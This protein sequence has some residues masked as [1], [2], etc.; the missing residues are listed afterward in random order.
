M[1]FKLVLR[2]IPSLLLVFALAPA[3]SQ[4]N[5]AATQGGAGGIPIMV[6]IGGADF[7]IDWGAG[8]R[9]EGVTAWVDYF[10]WGM[11]PKIH[12]IGIE[13]E[14]R[15]LNFNRPSGIPKMRQ[16]TGMAGVIYSMPYLNSFRP[17]GK[18]MFGIGSIDF[19]PNPAVP[20]YTHDT[21]QTIAP[22]GGIDY[23]VWGHLWARGEYE[24][25]FWHH[26]FGSHDL[27]PNGASF[28]FLYDFRPLPNIEEL[29][30]Q[31]LPCP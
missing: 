26:T 13:L 14:G 23:R 4:V 6:G 24:Y 31:D 16:D 18:V 10:P 29:A 20:Y 25:Q 21:F 3:S 15:D 12:G 19:P 28:G 22:A 5:P 11:S 27:N 2:F 1:R 9:M 17:F 8:T 7:A 30:G